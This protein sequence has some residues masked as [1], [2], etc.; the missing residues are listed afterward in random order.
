MK[1]KNKLL[2]VMVL[3]L[4]V[5]GIIVTGIWYWVCKKMSV[6]YAENISKSAMLDAYHAFEYILTDTAYMTTMI[7]IDRNNII[8][9][10]LT[11]STKVTK[12]NGQWNDVYLKNKRLILNYIT[13]I[14][15]YK[16][17][18]S[19][20]SVVVNKEC[21]FSSNH[22]VPSDE[23]VLSE[24]MALDREK[25]KNSVVMMKP[26]HMEG[27]KSNSKSDY[28]VPAVR[29]I[30]DSFG[31]IIGYVVV[32]FDYGVIDQMFSTSLPQNSIFFVTDSKKNLIYSNYDMSEDD[33]N[34]LSYG[35]IKSS[36]FADKV[37]WEFKIAIPT[38]YY[39]KRINYTALLSGV[40]IALTVVIS[41]I[42]CIILI[43]R[44]L[45]EITVLK[46]KMQ[47]IANGD[48]D[49]RYKVKANDEIGQMGLVFNSMI[50]KI[51]TLMETVEY[52]EREKRKAEISFL[53]AQINPH[54][55]SNTL[56]T[57]VWMAKIQHADNI[58]PLVNNLNSLLNSVIR[59][60]KE[61][62]LLKDELDYVD[63][64]L[65]IM[66]YNGN[67][68]FTVKKDIENIALNLYIPRFIL[69]PI[70]ENAIYHGK[71]EDLNSEITI[72]AF[73]EAEYLNIIISDNG[74]GMTKEEIEM[75]F[76]KD[77]SKYTSNKI[78]IKNVNERIKTLFGDEYGI[79]YES[80]PGKYTKCKFLLP[81][82]EN[83]Q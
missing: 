69:Q 28:V 76:A 74:V 2:M 54:F 4:T 22:I 81:K 83:C 63:R 45:R 30:L 71:S 61:L 44:M 82:K 60:K 32:Y 8:V 29:G 6:V 47:G 41:V 65:N 67:Y 24:I 34:N 23:G 46:N 62:V 27:M 17:Y 66:E 10:V 26:V 9:P 25:L 52:K 16:Y 49:I 48:M 38:E 18:I 14:D 58:V 31:N 3:I 21:V 39:T 43:S 37:A 20:I 13:S 36:F 75:I 70:L 5:S 72:K 7:A 42:I 19:G 53:Q 79:Y 12:E 55:L 59:E 68:D 77:D 64:Y 78:G 15:G 1:L 56:N 57:V 11:L 73:V 33:F 40:M 35:Y 51:E 50:D 80:R